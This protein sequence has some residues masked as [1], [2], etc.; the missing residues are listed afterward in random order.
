MLAIKTKLDAVAQPL[1][2]TFYHIYFISLLKAT[3]VA[4]ETLQDKINV[5]DNFKA[6]AGASIGNVVCWF[7]CGKM[8]VVGHTCF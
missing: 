2:L 6:L 8:L 3:L 1:T 7:V 4:R 5:L